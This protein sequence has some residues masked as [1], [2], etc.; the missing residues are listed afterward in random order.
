[1]NYPSP[2]LSLASSLRCALSLRKLSMLLAAAGLSAWTLA[3]PPNASAQV[4]VSPTSLTWAKVAVGNAGGPKV[5][6]LTNNG[7]AAITISSIAFTGTG[8]ADFTIYQKT[9]GTTLAS[10]ASCTVTVLFKPKSA[11]TFTAALA[12]TDNASGSPQEVALSGIGT[13]GVNTG[14]ASLSPSALSWNTVAIGNAGGPK[15]ATLTNTGSSTLSISSIGFTGTDPGDFSIYQKT[16][17]TALAA[18]ASCAATVLFKPTAS[19]TRTA[20]LT[21]GD[22]AGNSPQQVALTGMGSGGTTGT[23]SAAPTSLAY[24]SI[25]A[26]TTSAAKSITISNTTTA[27]VTLSASGLSGTGAADFA[28]ASTTCGSSLAAS[29]SCSANVVFKPAAAASYTATWS[30]TSSHSA[31]PLSVSLSGTGTATLASATVSP[32]SLNWIVVTIGN[33]GGPKTV[34]LTNT[35]T[36]TLNI[37]SIGFT[38]ANPGDFF[39]SSKTCGSTLPASASCTVAVRFKPTLGGARAATLAFTDN[40]TGS[41]QKVSLTGLGNGGSPIT[42][43]SAI[44]A[45]GATQQFTASVPSNWRTSCGSASQTG[46][47]TAPLTPS[48]C[49]VYADPTNGGSESLA[50][51]MVTTPI[52]VTPAAVNLHAMSTQQFTSSQPVTWTAS[53]GAISAAGLFTAPTTPGTCTITA[54]ASTGTALAATA[55][56]SI[57]VV[58]YTAW[59]GGGGLT[60][61]QTHELVLTPANVNSASFGLLWQAKVDGFVNA[62]PLYMNALTINGA[63]HNVV[64]IATANDSVYAL[65]GVTGTQLWQVSLLPAGATA[66]NSSLVAYADQ[67]QIGILSTPVIDPSTKTMYVVTESLEQNATTYPH[68][69]HALDVTTGQEK[70]GG[71]VLITNP[72]LAPIHKLQRPGLLL[73]N[74]S[75]YVAIGSLNDARPYNG[76]ILSFNAATLAQQSVWVVTPTG[77]EGG[78]WMGGAAPAVDENGD[79][80]VA[81]GNGTFDSVSNFGEAA[82]KLSPTLQLLDYFAPFNWSALSSKDTD[83]G[84]GDV[85]IAPDQNGPFPHELVVCGKPTPVYMLDRDNMGHAGTTSNNIVQTLDNQVGALGPGA[86]TVFACYTAP[87]MWQQKVYFG[88]KWDV[89]KMFTLNPSTGMLSPTPV[90]QDTLTFG[91]PGADPVVSANGDTNGIVWTIDPGTGTLRANDATNIANLF[92]SGSIPGGALRWTV[93]TVVNGHVYV[94]EEGLV[95]GFGL[96]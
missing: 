4:S 28:V 93:P 68:R 52:T 33:S 30:I 63:P 77:S 12:F 91:Y 15:V 14:S 24:G 34:T 6:T 3:A 44:L 58:N 27:A 80:Y 51:V 37:S 57:D 74:G 60:G 21:F 23:V 17:G 85:M 84:S 41:P 65:D 50:P 42:P 39:I 25:A 62:Q 82:V 10:A 13:G 71:P 76:M 7:S 40:A 89:L 54:K 55:T 19:G 86:T 5:A 69:L 67:P 72:Q 11:S 16:C 75:V 87:A 90:S 92:Y 78:I 45:E 18:S 32:A 22:S 43:A 56:A 47:Y 59:K 73:S 66:V 49:I 64:F 2:Q 31:T 83:L 1:M 79:I 38:G 36:T 48:N 8:G 46:L 95:F 88:G 61:A 53:C 81:T 26:H 70:F 94:A 35:G 96:K 29:A 20:S 9:C